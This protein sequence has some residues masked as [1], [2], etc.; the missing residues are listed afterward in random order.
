LGEARTAVVGASVTS[1]PTG[2]QLTT[3]N[4]A[5]FTG[6]CLR[7][8]RRGSA[9]M[10]S[11]RLKST[12]DDRCI[13]TAP[14]LTPRG[15]SV[16]RHVMV[17]PFPA[18]RCRCADYNVSSRSTG[19]DN[20]YAVQPTAVAEGV[21]S[22]GLLML[23]YTVAGPIAMPRARSRSAPRCRH[24]RRSPIR[25]VGQDDGAVRGGPRSCRSP[26]GHWGAPPE[27]ANEELAKRGVRS[28]SGGTSRSKPSSGASTEHL[29]TR[30]KAGRHPSSCPTSLPP[31]SWT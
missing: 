22:R 29:S 4:R 5:G 2:H 15:A 12:T 9:F 17:S 8:G 7:E 11:R 28:P 31:S 19:L 30:R 21:A 27:L 16:G 6:D 26:A 14:I 23:G 10:L 25:H 24:R 13:G 18:L 1:A 3:V 20:M